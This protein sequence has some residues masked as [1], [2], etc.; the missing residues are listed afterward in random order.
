MRDN[1]LLLKDL[2]GLWKIIFTIF[3]VV[4]KN[5]SFDVLNNIVD[6]CNNTYHTTIKMKPIDVKCNS[7][8]E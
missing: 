7:H 5:V 4:S 6:K 1:L 3:T 2:S 8:A